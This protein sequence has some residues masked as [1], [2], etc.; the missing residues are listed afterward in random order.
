MSH[1]Y[2]YDPSRQGNMPVPYQPPH[3]PVPQGYGYAPVQMTQ[4]TERGFNIV[5]C[6]VHVFLWLFLH[7]WI[8][9][10]T[11]GLWLL[12]AIPVTFIGWRVTRTIPVHGP[13][14][15]PRHGWQ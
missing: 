10:F 11:F 8:V 2:G 3:A 6:L 1:P 14:Y 4:I 5:T 7:S 9:V 13:A 15:P 12:V